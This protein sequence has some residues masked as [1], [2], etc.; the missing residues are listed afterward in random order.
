[1]QPTARSGASL[2]AGGTLLERAKERRFVRA[3]P[4]WP[5]ADAQVVRPS[6]LKTA[7]ANRFG[8]SGRTTGR[9]GRGLEADI[10]VL[11]GDPAQ[12]I[13]ALTRVRYALRQGRQVYARD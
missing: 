11:E 9:L 12:D 4:L 2:R 7:P 10:V 1:M 6:A 8:V 5:A 3:R 13:R